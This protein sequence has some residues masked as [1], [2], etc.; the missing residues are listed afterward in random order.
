MNDEKNQTSDVPKRKALGL[1]V[2][3]LVGSAAGLIGVDMLRTGQV[4]LVRMLF[5]LLGAVI[6]AG[7]VALLLMRR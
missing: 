5:T 7:I 6:G 1:F 2:G 3:V 4:D